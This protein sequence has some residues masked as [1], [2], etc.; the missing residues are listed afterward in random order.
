MTSRQLVAELSV[1]TLVVSPD[2]RFTA[3]AKVRVRWGECDVEGEGEC[4]VEGE[5]ECDVEGVH[6]ACR[7]GV[8]V[9]CGE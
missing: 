3:Q 9:G 8:G 5:G 2:S 4:E 6:E 7:D 1:A